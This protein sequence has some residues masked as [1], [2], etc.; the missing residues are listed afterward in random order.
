MTGSPNWLPLVY[1]LL[2][3]TW[4]CASD[5]D[6]EKT[7]PQP[8]AGT[9]VILGERDNGRVIKLA[10]GQALILKLVCQPGAGYSWGISQRAATRL[11][12][13][14]QHRVETAQ[15]SRVGQTEWQVF[16]LKALAAGNTNLELT[17][18]RPWEKDSEPLMTFRVELRIR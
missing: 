10:L 13:V 16:T 8:D 12:L 1:V 14:S 5:G 11:E 18:R 3:V 9:A 7:R 17:Y 4:S 15:D 6:R 2:S